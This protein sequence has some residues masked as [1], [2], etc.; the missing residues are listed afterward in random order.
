MLTLN[1][2]LHMTANPSLETLRQELENIINQNLLTALFQP[3]ASTTDRDIYAYEGLIRG[4]SSR[5][6]HS[7]IHLFPAAEKLGCLH[8]L[9]FSCRKAVIQAF[10]KEEL[11]GRLFLNVIPSCLAEQDFKPGAPSRY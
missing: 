10:V 1:I 11:A 9:D 6:L 8:A 2:W 3:I 5:F 7:P 4:P